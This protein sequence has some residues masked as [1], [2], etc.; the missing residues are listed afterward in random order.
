MDLE[1]KLT[2]S[3]LI[4]F[5]VETLT[6]TWLLKIP[7]WAPL[8]SILYFASGIAIAGLLLYFPAIRL[9]SPGRKPWQSPINQRRL[10][11]TGLI[12]LALYSW[13]LYWFDEM[14]IDISNAD[15]L[16]IIKV[17]GER[18][19]AGQHGHIYDPIPAIW[20]GALPIYLPAMWLPYV[21]ALAMGI[22]MRWIAIA[23]LLFSFG[24]F[25]FLYR[26]SGEMPQAALPSAGRSHQ[27]RGSFFLGVLAF[28]LF[29]WIVAD[30]TAGVVSVSEE[31]VVIGYYILL[32]LAL[33]SGKPWLT[34][35]AISLCMLSRYALVGW[36]PAYLIYLALE[37]RWRQLS[38]ITLTG[39][40]CFTLLFLVPVGWTTFMRL[41]HLPGNYVAFADRVWNDSPNVFSTAPGLAWFFG[42][43]GVTILHGLLITFSFTLPALF[44]VLAYRRAKSRSG[45]AAASRG[46]LSNIPLASLKLSLVIFYSFIDVPYLYLFY[47]S[48]L[49]SLIVMALLITPDRRQVA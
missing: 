1:K 3:I 47:T 25:V 34:G 31:G 35:I 41:I 48:S 37:R 6:A 42:R 5:A 12:A 20:H 26:P 4:A 43:K 21:P 32:V 39:I 23:G 46:C 8:F 2:P 10:V 27:T 16:P 7:G 13:C 38:I 45:D 36:I 49:V 18:F 14:P 24:T 11:I 33:L 28:L 44:T 17:M 22:D 19:I 15:M 29:W 30:N 9:P 40:L